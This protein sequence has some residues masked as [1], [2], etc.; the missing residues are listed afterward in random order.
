M[1]EA[2]GDDA[3]RRRNRRKSMAR[4]SPGVHRVAAILNFFAEH[5]GQA[6][7]LTEVVKSLKI[8]RATCHTLLTGLV[9]VGYLHRM[10]GKS[11]VIGPVMVAIARNVSAHHSPLQVVQPEIRALADEFDAI[12]SAAFR[13]GDDVVVRERA[14]SVS[15]LGWSPPLGT[16]LPLRAPF[17]GI[18]FAWSPKT[19]VD[20][21]LAGH[22][23]PVSAEL[24]ALMFEA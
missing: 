13:E 6:F 21:W 24:R 4:S 8:T 3:T 11:Y 9:E 7:T 23:P 16:R 22:D 18:F 19:E 1:L 2:R 12:C 14:A 20:A 10:N 17:A 5:T 15:N